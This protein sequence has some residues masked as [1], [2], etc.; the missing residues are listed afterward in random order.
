[1]EEHCHRHRAHISLLCS[2]C[3]PPQLAFR[4]ITL[5]CGVLDK[6]GGWWLKERETILRGKEVNGRQFICCGN[7]ME[8]YSPLC[9]VKCPE[10]GLVSLQ[11]NNFSTP[12]VHSS[13]APPAA[14]AR[15]TL[16]RYITRATRAKNE[17][18]TPAPYF[19]F[20]PPH[21]ESIRM[22]LSNVT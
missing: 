3:P 7:G 16:L 20:P 1:M 5:F 8:M 9:E 22:N 10:N 14:A 21:S 2:S 13:H 4:F 12:I 19:A 15:Q 6:V 17:V 18:T 11:L